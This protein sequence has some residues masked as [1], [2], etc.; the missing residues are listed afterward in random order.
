MLGSVLAQGIYW[1][2]RPIER[3][4]ESLAQY[5]ARTRR[6]KETR[7]APNQNPSPPP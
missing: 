7:R 5:R 2:T 4:E 3:A 6:R 1:G